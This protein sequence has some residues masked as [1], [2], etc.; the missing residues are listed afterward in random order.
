M[1]LSSQIIT[2]VVFL[3]NLLV[4]YWP[5]YFMPL[6]PPMN[7]YCNGYKILNIPVFKHKQKRGF[8][9][10]AVKSKNVW[11]IQFWRENFPKILSQCK[12]W[13]Q[14]TC[15]RTNMG[16]FRV[17]I[18]LHIVIILLTELFDGQSQFHLKHR[19]RRDVYLNFGWNGE[20]AVP[21][22]FAYF[23]Y[24]FH[25][26]IYCVSLVMVTITS[27]IFFHK[28]QMGHFSPVKFAIGYEEV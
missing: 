8:L 1:P 11:Q 13:K 3:H 5:S 6:A 4:I 12:L 20:A 23:S 15:I 18:P 17:L 28:F 10:K 24:I 2:R 9:K 7:C 27:H 25:I 21:S 14:N 26:L 22:N 16:R 19:H